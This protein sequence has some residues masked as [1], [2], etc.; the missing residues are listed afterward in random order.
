MCFFGCRKQVFPDIIHTGLFRFDVQV[1]YGTP[2]RLFHVFAA[3][4][5]LRISDLPAHPLDIMKRKPGEVPIQ[6]GTTDILSHPGSLMW[7]R[8]FLA[9]FEGVADLTVTHF[10]LLHI[11]DES[12]ISKIFRII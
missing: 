4:Q 3:P 10:E 8:N 7:A 11:V 9:A 1:C 6:L 2:S 12:I 5:P